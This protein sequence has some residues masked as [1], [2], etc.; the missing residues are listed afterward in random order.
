MP[1]LVEDSAEDAENQRDVTAAFEAAKYDFKK[2]P[3][4]ETWKDQ[5]SAGNAQGRTRTKLLILEGSS[6]L[7]KTLFAIDLFKVENT[8][9]IKCPGVQHPNLSAYDAGQHQVIVLDDPRPEQVG[10][11]RHLLQA[12]RDPRV[13]HQSATQRY[14]V[15]NCLYNVPIIICSNDWSSATV[16]VDAEL[17][18]WIKE[19]SVHYLVKDSLYNK[20]VEEQS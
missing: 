12:G 9:V 6:R 10:Q 4:I 16:N 15:W 5:F 3:E 7:G 11:Y 17:A 14:E 2:I 13:V 19:N 20:P 1:G 18:A 8:C